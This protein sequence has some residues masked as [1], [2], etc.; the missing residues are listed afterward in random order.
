MCVL[1]NPPFARVVRG[2]CFGEPPFFKGGKGCVFW[3]TPP[4]SRV[5]RGVR[6]GKLPLAK[7]IAHMRLVFPILLDLHK[8]GNHEQHFEGP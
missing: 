7:E 2:V 8:C 1:G 5:V 6:F 4:F 3:G